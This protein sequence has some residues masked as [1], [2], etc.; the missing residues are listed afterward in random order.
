MNY[1]IIYLD[2]L[3][4]HGIKGQQWGKRNGPPYPL[5]SGDHSAREKKA[6]WR[7]SLKSKDVYNQA[8]SAARSA[9][10]DHAKA[11]NKAYNYSALHPV[12]Q[13]VKG[14]KSNKKS[15]ELWDDEKAKSITYKEAVKK[16]NSTKNAY[17]ADRNER[18]NKE[19]ANILGVSEKDAEQIK[20]YAKIVGISL[21]TTAGLVAAGYLISRNRQALSG[22]AK[23]FI[24]KG[25]D[26]LNTN[27]IVGK[28][29]KDASQVVE[30]INR[31]GAKYTYKLSDKKLFSNGVTIGSV[32]KTNG[33]QRLSANFIKDAINNPT[34]HSDIESLV[35]DVRINQ[36][37]IYDGAR[38]LSCWSTSQSYFLSSLTGR[39][40]CSM[41]F[42]NLVDFNDF[43]KLYKTQP[44]IFDAFGKEAST[45]VGKFG[46]GAERIKF[47]E[48][49]GKALISNIFD[50]IGASNNLT[51]EG[52]RTIGFINAG[53]R[54]MTCTHQWNFEIEHI[55]NGEKILHIVDGYSGERYRVAKKT[56]NGVLGFY[57][58]SGD[59]TSSGFGKFM[60][61][62]Y[63]Y[64]ADS[65][66]FYAPS[67]DSLNPETIARIILGKR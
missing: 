53:Y 17:K 30:N 64:N 38:R 22:I 66:R 12:S 52:K 9:K 3:Y 8:R 5:G 23:N 55:A 20:K 16:L 34:V 43:G 32:A 6:G 47:D 48:A 67:L 45:F 14:S 44:K 46:K 49:K 42:E 4:H 59:P 13:Y 18:S 35:K 50:N 10:K 11:Y 60:T 39:N 54:G 15:K 58:S 24:N 41:S 62:L 26:A 65:L 57:K 25:K 7:S 27:G 61:E 28:I 29:S 19:I 51:V 1:R 33:Y 36:I 37:G 21:A 2:E 40:F 56:V 31:S 63:H